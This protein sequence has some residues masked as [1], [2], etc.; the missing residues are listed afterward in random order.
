MEGRLGDDDGSVGKIQ[1]GKEGG[2][3]N[4]VDEKGIQG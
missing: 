4:F 3:K 2:F 1:G